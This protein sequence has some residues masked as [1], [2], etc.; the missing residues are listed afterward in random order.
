MFYT[1][2]HFRPD[3]RVFYIGKGSGNR[4]LSVSRSRY[5]QNVVKKEGS[6]T[7]E[8]LARWKT[9]QEAFEHEKFLIKCFRDL[10]FT[11]CNLTDGGEGPS[12]AVRS[13]ETRAKLSAATKAYMALPGDRGMRGKTQ[14][15][16]MREKVSSALSGRTFS[17]ETLTKMSLSHAGK[18]VPQ[19]VRDKIRQSCS[20]KTLSDEHRSKIGDA[21]RGRPQSDEVRA[22]RSA[23]WKA[24]NAEKFSKQFAEG[25]IA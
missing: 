1:Y 8:I 19:D 5:W 20:G 9:E 3:G 22:A 25:A 11:L 16:S 17:H 18:V 7:A 14:S 12:G 10:G 4:Y 24:K 2:A 15:K 23:L 6:F 13:I 21:L